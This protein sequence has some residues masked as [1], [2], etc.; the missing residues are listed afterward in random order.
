MEIW[1]CKNNDDI[2]LIVPIPIHPISTETFLITAMF[3]FDDLGVE[4]IADGSQRLPVGMKLDGSIVDPAEE[5]SV[6]MA[7]DGTEI[8]TQAPDGTSK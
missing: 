4:D 2:F 8:T 3:L 1:V 5:G 7:S 6:Q